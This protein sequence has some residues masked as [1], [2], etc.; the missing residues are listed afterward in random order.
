[1]IEPADPIRV[2][3]ALRD[4][5]VLTHEYDDYDTEAALGRL[6]TPAPRSSP[7]P[8]EARQPLS[9]TEQA[10]H[11]LD[12]AAAL[13]V[14][15]PQAATSLK[16]FLD[17][18]RIDPAGALVFATLLYLAGYL[19]GAQ[20]WWQFAA[21]SGDATA[22]FCLFLL[23]EQ[24][25]EFRDARYW[26]DQGKDLVRGPGASR[27]SRRSSRLWRWVRGRRRPRR[28]VPPGLLPESIRSDLIV[29]CHQGD[30]PLLPPRVRALIHSL[31][32]ECDDEVFGEIPRPDDRLAS[33]EQHQPASRTETTEPAQGGALIMEF[34]PRGF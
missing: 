25:A 11:D 26:R 34:S 16:R 29:R 24:Q 5:Q 8:Q 32:V 1:M 28:S 18:E 31:P 12:L 15:A 21:G 3:D 30:R 19:E 6:G 23:H 20:F 4:A 9:R 22:A 14:D 33:L 10:A 27:E 17:H 13:I 7:I 2:D